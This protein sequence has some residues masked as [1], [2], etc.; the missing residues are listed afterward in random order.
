MIL[1]GKGVAEWIGKVVECPSIIGCLRIAGPAPHNALF[2]PWSRR[3]L[4][5]ALSW[6][7]WSKSTLGLEGSSPSWAA[8]SLCSRT[9]SAGERMLAW[10]SP[11]AERGSLQKSALPPHLRHARS[12]CACLRCPLFTQIVFGALESRW[13]AELPF[14]ESKCLLCSLLL[15]RA[16]ILLQGPCSSFLPS[17]LPEAINL[18]LWLRPA[19]AFSSFVFSSCL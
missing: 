16:S 1:Y 9:F 6:A 14:S 17:G 10:P 11:S 15:I 19:S 18:S 4:H 13:S 2:S 8:P 3:A 7:T 12:S 5:W